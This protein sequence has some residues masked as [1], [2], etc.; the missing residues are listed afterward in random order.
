MM[1]SWLRASYAVRDLD[2]SADRC[3]GCLT[4]AMVGVDVRI[5]QAG[6]QEA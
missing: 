5:G 6:R 2:G 4:S 1:S 3:S